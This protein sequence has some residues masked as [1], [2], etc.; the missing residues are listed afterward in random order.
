[1]PI[2][3]VS[4]RHFV[5]SRKVKNSHNPSMADL[6]VFIGSFNATRNRPTRQLDDNDSGSDDGHVVTGVRPRPAFSSVSPTP[7][8]STAAQKRALR[9][10]MLTRMI[11]EYHLKH[12]RHGHQKGNAIS[13]SNQAVGV[14]N[15]KREERSA[16]LP[17]RSNT[18]NGKASNIARDK[19]GTKVDDGTST[20][21]MAVGTLPAIANPAQASHRIDALRPAGRSLTTESSAHASER[22][23]AG[24]SIEKG[25]S[26]TETLEHVCACCGGDGGKGHGRRCRH[27]FRRCGFCRVEEVRRVLFGAEHGRDKI[28]ALGHR[29]GAQV[30]GSLYS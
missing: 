9:L 5:I 2:A 20:A 21:R 28:A 15:D 16:R 25:A 14:G 30:R 23:P 22:S 4:R 11:D 18:N 26:D 10:E 24:D 13:V 19:V 6:A 17:P 12:G 29:G 8:K 7:A 3:S 27:T 1:M